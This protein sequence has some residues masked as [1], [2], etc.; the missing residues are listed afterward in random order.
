MNQ[1]CTACVV[2]MCAASAAAQVT[3][4][5]NVIQTIGSVLPERSNANAAYLSSVYTPNL[6]VEEPCTVDVVFVWEGAGYRNT[7]G[8]FTYEESPAGG[9]TITSSDL[10]F[11]NLSFPPQGSMAIGDVATLRGSDGFPRTFQ[12]GERIGFFLIANGFGSATSTVVNWTYSPG[13][14][15][16]DPAVNAG[17]GLGCYTSLPQLNREAII[18]DG[19]KSQHVAMLRMPGQPGFLDGEDY[20]VLAFEDLNRTRGSDDDFNDAVF[21]VRTSP[22]TAISTSNFFNYD[23]NDSDGDGVLGVEDH[24][25]DD[26][27][28]AYQARYPS[29][30]ESVIA[31]ED[32]YP[33]I[34][35]ADFND[36]VVAFHYVV[37]TDAA[38]DVKDIVGDFHLVA[39][40]AAFDHAFGVHLA[41]LPGDAS[42]SVSIERIES[43]DTSGVVSS[44]TVAD[45]IAAGN[46]VPDIFA[47][48]T[49]ALP[50]PA[51]YTFSNTI[52][53]A[54]AVDAA[55]TRF[56]IEFDT[57]IA[58]ASVGAPPYDPFLSVQR[59]TAEPWDIH[60]PGRPGLSGRPAGLPIEAG[61]GSFLDSNGFPWALLVPTSWRHPMEV[62]D[63]ENAY[64]QFPAWRTSGG[65]A[66][67]D[68][69]VSPNSGAGFVGGTVAARLPGRSWTVLGPTP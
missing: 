11:S 21:I 56:H 13:I 50:A 17:I 60:L 47:S 19:S 34:G 65:A 45:V 25:P 57:A 14:P 59:F 46:C 43:G 54:P 16:N 6:L 4:P 37:V 2:A 3:V 53:G 42:G 62:Q 69:Y 30:G 26:P 18:G 28:R 41:G 66:N 48:T 35:D 33:D 1:L 5:A 32:K 44:R 51:G 39:R 7:V 31:F 27:T 29:S 40:G 22:E 55:S 64:P 12:P 38:G 8:Y 20:N 24:F 68:W 61:A 49:A 23:P 10:L 9:V 67:Q 36:A 63:I 52:F 58:A 15:S